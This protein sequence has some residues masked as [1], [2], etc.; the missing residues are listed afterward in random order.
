M[1]KYAW[2]V[3]A[4][5][6]IGSFIVLLASIILTTFDN[7]KQIP[8]G[9]DIGALITGTSGITAITSFV[10]KYIKRNK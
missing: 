10:I 9:V 6:T 8:I 3:L 4:I 7:N 2:Y 5:I 1:N